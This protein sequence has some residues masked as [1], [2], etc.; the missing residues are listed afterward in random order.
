MKQKEQVFS[1]QLKHVIWIFVFLKL[2]TFFIIAIS[3]SLLPFNA[4]SFEANFTYPENQT[5]NFLTSFATWDS[6]HYIAIA[7]VGYGEFVLSNAFY[8]LYPFLMYLVSFI[9]QN[10]IVAGLIV[11]TVL[12]FLAI[13]YFYKFVAKIASQ[14]VAFIALLLF[15]LF[16]TAFY[17]NLIYTEALFLFLLSAL[18]YYLYSRSFLFASLFLFLL[19]FSRTQGILI[20]LPLFIFIVF[21]KEKKISSFS[22]GTFNENIVIRFCKEYLLLLSPILG[23]CGYLVTMYVLTGD[24]FASYNAQKYF[25]GQ[26]SALNIFNPVLFFH[27]LFAPIQSIHLFTNSLIDRLFFVL[28]LAN[29][30][31]VYKKTDKP[32]F[33]LYVLMGITPFLGSFMAY[34]RYLLLAI[35]LFIAWGEIIYEKKWFVPALIIGLS[36]LSLQVIFIMLYALNYWVS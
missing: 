12:S 5:I 8:P 24:P 1:F 18:L 31:L 16:P 22:I 19:P 32:L 6:Q 30:P 29:L 35:P 7:K 10:V 20:L 25:I 36:L 9:T 21:D 23:Y 11:S 26:Y 13:I 15:L 3:S 17:I 14:N 4:T 27:N 34:T 28:Y 2:L 33:F